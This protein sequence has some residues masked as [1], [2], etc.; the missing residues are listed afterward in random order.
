MSKVKC[1]QKFRDKNNNIIGYRLQDSNGSTRDVTPQQLKAVMK[2]CK[3]E[4]SNLALTSDNRLIDKPINQEQDKQQVRNL[5]N[6][7][8][9]ILK[10]MML[11]CVHNLKTTCGH[12]IY[13]ANIPNRESIMYI[14]DDV[15][16]AFDLATAAYHDFSGSKL[17]VYGGNNLKSAKYLFAGNDFKEIDLSNF[18]T[19]NITDM[20]CMFRYCKTILLN[21]SNFNTSNVTNMADMFVGVKAE[22]INLSHFDTS[23]VANMYQMFAG[24]K[25]TS[26]DL[27]S[28]DTSHV[29]DMEHMFKGC[30]IEYVDASHFKLNQATNIRYMFEDCNIGSIIL[31]D[32][33]RLQKEWNKYNLG[34]K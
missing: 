12:T 25:T 14:P 21:L 20:S 4:I 10:M 34:R 16:E 29:S 3:L 8:N 17:K 26:L 22:E 33:V 27:S 18:G 13:L 31:G 6:I 11:G 5:T 9:K 30:N 32:D 23:N 7:K 2:Q 1:I 19:G 15:T 28:F 24:C